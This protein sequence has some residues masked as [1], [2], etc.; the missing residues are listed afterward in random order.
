ME[1]PEELV[2]LTKEIMHEYFTGNTEKWF[3]YM[4]PRCVFVATGETFLYGIQNIKKELAP[5]ASQGRCHVLSDE[6]FHI[7]LN[8]KVT[9][10]IAYTVTESR[11][12]KR[13]HIV[14]MISFVWQIKRKQ[15]RIVYEHASYR[16]YQEEKKNIISPLKIENNNFQ[17]AR[18]LS[19]GA[20]Q[21]K[22]ISFFHGNKTM[23]LDISLIL[24]IEGNGHI[25]LIHCLSNIFTCTQ[26]LTELKKKLP[27]TFYQIHRSYIVNTDYLL[28]VRC[29][30]A[31]LIGGIMLPVP[32]AKY[33]Q[34]KTDLGKL[35]SNKSSS[36]RGYSDKASQE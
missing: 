29:Y 21:K 6:Y 19:M 32:A 10:V 12:T 35:L 5:I 7:P 18:H 17:I 2:K 22:R 33:R 14:N 34:V 9:V 3:Q 20:A 36:Q 28:S 1:N 27:E 23:Y 31:E 30:E 26:S 13:T 25:S 16:F 8:K 15:P 4:D 11:N 24:Y